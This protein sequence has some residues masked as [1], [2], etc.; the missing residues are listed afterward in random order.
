MKGSKKIMLVGFVLVMFASGLFSAISANELTEAKKIIDAGTACTNLSNEQL[1]LIGESYMEQMHPGDA[2]ELMHKMMG[3][4]EGSDTEKQFHVNMAKTIYCN[5]S[6]AGTGMMGS[7]M[8][9]GM[10]GNNLTTNGM[11][12]GGIAGNMMGNGAGSTQWTMPY[13]TATSAGN[14]A[15][16]LYGILYIV[17]LIGLII[18]VYL[19]IVKLWKYG[20]KKE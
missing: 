1:E 17:L 15:S 10:M 14:W 6:N 3:L 18:L 20:N 12:A 19:A 8:I 13:G 4:Q 9:G 2:H 5:E 11:M 7:G 16:N